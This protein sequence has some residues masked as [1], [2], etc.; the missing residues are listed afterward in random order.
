MSYNS[1]PISPLPFEYWSFYLPGTPNCVP[2]PQTPFPFLKSFISSLLKYHLFRVAFLDY[3]TSN[4]L[5]DPASYY[6]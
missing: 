1:P 3:S 6:P 5:I 4:S 2:L